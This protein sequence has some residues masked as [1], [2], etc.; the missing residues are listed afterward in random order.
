M[1]ILTSKAKFHYELYRNDEWIFSALTYSEIFDEMVRDNVRT[2]FSKNNKYSYKVIP[3]LSP[4]IKKK[5]TA[6]PTFEVFRDGELLKVCETIKEVDALIDSDYV[7]TGRR[8]KYTVNVV[9]GKEVS[10]G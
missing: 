3:G 6:P 7:S 4:L 2:G 5:S 8:G 10:Y 9:A 1:Q